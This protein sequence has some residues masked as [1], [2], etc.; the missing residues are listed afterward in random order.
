METRPIE[1]FPPRRIETPRLVL[2]LPTLTD[3]PAIHENWCRHASVAHYLSWKPHA[4]VAMTE[5]YVA[6]VRDAWDL[7]QGMRDWVLV[8]KREDGSEGEP[9]GSIGIALEWPRGQLGYAMGPAFEGKG[10]MSEAVDAVVHAALTLPC[11]R[12]VPWQP[13]GAPPPIK[14]LSRVQAFVDPDNQRSINVLERNGFVREGLLR[15]YLVQPNRGDVARDV[16]LY[17][18]LRIGLPRE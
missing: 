14:V 12:P 6:S 7:E 15:Q 5:N 16:Y 3:A 13:A 8:P 4:Y 17:A 1:T 9:L 2:R 11:P 10:Y 18:R